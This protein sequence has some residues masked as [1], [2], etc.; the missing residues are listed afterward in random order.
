MSAAAAPLAAAPLAAVASHGINATAYQLSTGESLVRITGEA[1]ETHIETHT[2]IL[3]DLSGSMNANG[4]L[5]SVTRSLHFMLDLMMPS[6]RLSLVTFEQDAK[7]RF[8]RLALTAE[9][10]EVVR[11]TLGRLVADGG[12]N[13]S[14]GIV[15]SRECLF[16]PS[17]VGARMKQSILLL[18]DGH[19][20]VGVYDPPSVLRHVGALLADHPG[21][22][23]STIGYGTDHNADLRSQIATQGSGSYNVV[24]NIEDVAT[25]F[26]DIL[27]GIQ[28]CIAQQMKLLIPSAA[29]TQLT[30][31][32]ATTAENLTTITLGDL[33]AG[34]EHV[35]LLNGLTQAMGTLT[36]RA[37]ETET[38][39]PV[40]ITFPL[41]T[42]PTDSEA[43]F[44]RLTDRKSVV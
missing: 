32:L 31:F 21:L 8:S 19:A 14:A 3:L 15:R 4:K 26:G 5:A 39:R 28:T 10:K 42:D 24:S 25:V 11:I 41:R 9:N 35:V 6:D 36:L 12:T 18:T 29:V 34:G 2:I 30:P 7:V 13:L 27:G 1:R 22:T 17:D 40:E 38:G 20:N 16:A 44:G 33:P 37:Y 23:V 43:A